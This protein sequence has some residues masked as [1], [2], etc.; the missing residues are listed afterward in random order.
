M[1]ICIIENGLVPEQLRDA[2][3]MYPQMARDWLAPTLPEARFTTIS[4]VSG[5]AL[6]DDP[7]AFD[8]YLLT[9]SKYGVYDNLPWMQA[10]QAFLRRAAGA[11]VPM[12]GICFGHQIMAAAF[13][14]EVRKSDK[15]VA[16]G[17]QVYTFGDLGLAPQEV[18]VFHQDQVETLPPSARSSG[19]NEFCPLGVIVYDFPAFSVQYHP[20]F[21]TAFMQDLT[22]D[23]AGQW[24]TR[25]HAEDAKARLAAAQVDNR[26]LALKVAELMRR[27]S[28]ASLAAS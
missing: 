23:L 4:P 1:K 25:E 8:G 9:G 27:R 15:G 28:L 16:T 3:G 20:E 2:H 18:L 26:P 14:G 19:G 10:L 13:G 12:V 11:Q 7:L 5:E 6:P 22:D 24:I 17:P 21:S